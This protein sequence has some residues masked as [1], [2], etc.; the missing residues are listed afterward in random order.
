MVTLDVLR[1]SPS[2]GGLL[3]FVGGCPDGAVNVAEEVGEVRMPAEM[4]DHLSPPQHVVVMLQSQG[5]GRGGGRGNR[6]G[7]AVV[8][9]ED[10]ETIRCDDS[11]TM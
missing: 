2:F 7:S 6:H 5:D 4:G 1:S 10:E 8:E 9:V 11:N 3:D